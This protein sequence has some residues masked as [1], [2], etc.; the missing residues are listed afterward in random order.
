MDQ[1]IAAL[2]AGGEIE[3]SIFSLVAGPAGRLTLHIMG[4]PILLK[5]GSHGRET[6]S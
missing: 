5:G 6:D 2:F 3:R 4:Q 1:G